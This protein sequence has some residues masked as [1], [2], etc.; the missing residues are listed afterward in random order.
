MKN[1]YN[2]S[3]KLITFCICISLRESQILSFTDNLLIRKE[4]RMVVESQTFSGLSEV[5]RGCSCLG[6]RTTEG[7][8]MKT[9]ETK[10]IKNFMLVGNII[11][12]KNK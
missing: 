5:Q 2:L 8:T 7:D 6:S 3:K 9:K 12:I 4:R 11:I 10:K 1:K